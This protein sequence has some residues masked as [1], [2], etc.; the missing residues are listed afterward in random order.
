MAFPFYSGVEFN[1]IDGLFMS[2]RM[3]HNEL[4][5]IAATTGLTGLAAYLAVLAAF[6]YLWLKAYRSASA[7]VRWMLTGVLAAAAAYQVQNLFS[8]GVAGIN[9]LWFFCL[10]AV[11][12]FASNTRRVPG[13]QRSSAGHLRKAVAVLCVLFIL[14]FPLMRLSADVAY[15]LGDSYSAAIRKPDP[16]ISADNLEQF[17]GM[18]I[19]YLTRAVDLFPWDVKYQLYMGLAY[20]QRARLDPLQ[21]HEW[22]L[23]AL[24]YYE[25]ASRISPANAYYYS[26]IGRIYSSMTPPDAKN[27][28]L[29]EQ[30]YRSAARW[31]PASPFF[32][33]TWAGSLD[34]AGQTEEAE[35]QIK[36]SFALDPVFSGKVLSQ[37]AFEIYQSGDRVKAFH[38]MNEAVEG[39]PSSPE[40]YF[41]RG[42]LYL[43]EKNKKKALADLEKAKELN[44]D[45]FKNPSVQHLDE[46]IAQA[47]K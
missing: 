36:R 14:A 37:M 2:S 46:F 12:H 9:L 26:N 11:D 47:S 13:T 29:A 42:I 41:G 19:H 15:G 43:S 18:E 38:F 16:Q 4:L 8:F 34:K 27:L 20:E 33:L 5:Q 24:T 21:S 44:P 30:S 25:K 6:I 45:P 3:A 35:K 17:S 32:I 31:S 10:A 1:Q 7:P 40:A 39:N 22:F 28:A 23:K